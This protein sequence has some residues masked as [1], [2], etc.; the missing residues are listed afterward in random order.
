MFGKLGTR[1]RL[2]HARGVSPMVLL[3]VMAAGGRGTRFLATL[4]GGSATEVDPGQS[5]RHG[6]Y[7]TLINASRPSRLWENEPGATNE[8][9]AIAVIP[10]RDA[11]IVEEVPNYLR[12]RMRPN[13]D[14]R[15]N[16]TVFRTNRFG[17]RT[18]EV[19]PEKRDG[20]YRI[21]VF[22]SS[23]TMGHGVN[24]EETYPRRLERW[25]NEETRGAPRVEVVNLAVAGEPPTCRLQRLREEGERIDADWLLCDATVFDSI[26]EA[27][28]LRAVVSRKI[29][30]PLGFV[31]EAIRRSGAS[32][33]DTAEAFERKLGDQS[34]ALLDGAYA[35]WSA[36]AR[37]R[38]V[39]LSVVILPRSDRRV[40]S[41]RMFRLIRTL[42]SRHALECFDLSGAFRGLDADQIP[43]SRWDNHPG[44][45]GHRAIFEAFRAT[46]ID[47]GGPPGLTLSNH[48][49]TP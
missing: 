30:I 29:P 23:N 10:F 25:L 44:P 4:R 6:Y 17:Y 39:P 40:E 5:Y 46:L 33:A 27:E 7:E 2:R 43:V 3:L 48:R 22:G 47:R 15:W 45:L 11:G 16:G 9:P 26:L 32:A 24:D 28:H 21:A 14:L 42:A 34:E 35:G 41:L 31:R 37:Q 49:R 19:E 36:E 8:P 1:P 38:G 18:P 12:W 13:L 20:T